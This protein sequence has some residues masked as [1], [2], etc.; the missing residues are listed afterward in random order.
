MIHFQTLRICDRDDTGLAA[1][2]RSLKTSV[3]I[4]GGVLREGSRIGFATCR[5]H[6]STGREG[7]A[8]ETGLASL[9]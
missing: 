1:V 2:V 8:K 9:G 3:F 7:K 6:Y 5:Y 4:G